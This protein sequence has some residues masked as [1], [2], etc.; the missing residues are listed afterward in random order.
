MR[1]KGTREFKKLL[2]MNERGRIDDV[3]VVRSRNGWMVF[4]VESDTNTRLFVSP[5]LDIILDWMVDEGILDET[6]FRLTSRQK[7]ILR[8]RIFEWIATA[9]FGGIGMAIMFGLWIAWFIG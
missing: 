1:Y 7:D 4:K 5:K 6:R 2:E 8:Q 9:I 3:R